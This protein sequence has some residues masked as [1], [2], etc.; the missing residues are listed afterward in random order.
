MQRHEDPDLCLSCADPLNIQSLLTIAGDHALEQSMHVADR[1][2]QC[3]DSGLFHELFGLGRARE[4]FLQVWRG[5]VDFRAAADVANLAFHKNV[6]TRAF[7]VST[8]AFVS[9]TFSSNGSVERS[10]T[11]QSNPALAASSNL[12]D[13]LK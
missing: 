11:I 2:G 7:K 10:N 13:S 6:R 8:A 5:T 4:S 9:R 12:H 1:R 3:V